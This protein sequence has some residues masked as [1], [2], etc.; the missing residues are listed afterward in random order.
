M[1]YY[2]GYKLGIMDEKYYPLAGQW[3]DKGLEIPGWPVV[4]GGPDRAEPGDVIA[5]AHHYSDATGHVGIV[6]GP[7]QTASADSTVEEAP[8]TITISGPPDD[9]VPGFGF[10]AWD[11]F[12]ADVPPERRTGLK[13]TSILRR[14]TP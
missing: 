11:D 9:D 4:S 1:R 5:E 3:A 14:F 6:V 12:D 2:L 8:G 13:D 7:H 10:R